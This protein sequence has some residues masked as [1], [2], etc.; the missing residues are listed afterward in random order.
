M[1]LYILIFLIPFL[2]NSSQLGWLNLDF[3][4]GG[5]GW[6]FLYSINY[7]LLHES[8]TFSNLH[9]WDWNW[10][11]WLLVILFVCTY[12]LLLLLAYFAYITFSYTPIATHLFLH[13]LGSM[14]NLSFFNPDP[15]EKLELGS[16]QKLKQHSRG[17]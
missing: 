14:Q 2:L 12:Q 6:Y 10:H 9:L 3:F 1:K 17:N 16:S 4:Q 15:Q 11:P 13:S 5:Q 8:L 7:K